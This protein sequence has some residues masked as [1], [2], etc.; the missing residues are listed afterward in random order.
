MINPMGGCQDQQ[1]EALYALP[2]DAGIMD[3]NRDVA[4]VSKQFF[5]QSLHS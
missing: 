3:E 1:Q 2:M 5:R 4:P